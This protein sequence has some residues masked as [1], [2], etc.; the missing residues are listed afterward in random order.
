MGYI[1]DL[2]GLKTLDNKVIKERFLLRSAS[3]DNPT[4]KQREYLKDIKLKRIFDLRNEKEAEHDP[5]IILDNVQYYNYSIIDSDLNGIT[6][7]ERSKQLELLKEIPTMEECYIGM[8]TDEYSL[9][10]IKTV[11]RKIVLEDGFPTIVHC[12]TGK[13]RAGMITMLL[14]TILNVDYELIVEDYLKQRPLYINKA[15]KLYFLLLIATFD[16]KLA[17]KVYDYYSVDRKFID[18]ARNTINK[19]F[20][21]MDNF[22]A[23]YLELTDSEINNFKEKAL[24]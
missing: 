11:I 4:S 3:L 22:I 21:S 18:T 23:Q 9:K 15:R 7:Q 17:R 24:S 5:D 6:H 19:N 8:F 2:G 16:L 14:L 1:R 13:D 20:G 12:V 10:K